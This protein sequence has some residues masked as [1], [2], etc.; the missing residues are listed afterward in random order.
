MYAK[1]SGILMPAMD[2]K[3]EQNQ[4]VEVSP[5]VMEL[6]L[7]ELWQANQ[8]LN[9][10]RCLHLLQIMNELLQEGYRLNSLE[11]KILDKFMENY[12]VNY[13]SPLAQAMKE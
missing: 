2:C 8:L 5:K 10:S 12:N 3:Q 1:S 11:Q 13:K 9:N 4:P 6:D 7:D